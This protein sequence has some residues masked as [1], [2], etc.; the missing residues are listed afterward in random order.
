MSTPPFPLETVHDVEVVSAS[1]D[2]F[3]HR[4][5][6][7][8]LDSVVESHSPPFTVGILGP[9]GSGKSTIKSMYQERV[10]KKDSN[11]VHT[12][13]FNAWRHAAEDIKRALLRETYRG[14]NGS[15]SELDLFLF[16]EQSRAEVQS[17]GYWRQVRD[18]FKRAG[19]YLPLI[20]AVFVIL[21]APALIAILLTDNASL[22]YTLVSLALVAS[23]FASKLLAGGF[24]VSDLE[25]I[26]TTHRRPEVVDEQYQQ[27]LIGQISKFK[28]I[29]KTR[30][31]TKIVIF[32]DDLDRIP[33]EQTV[34][35][36]EAIRVFTDIPDD[37]LEK[38]IGLVF[39]LSCDEERIAQ[40]LEVTKSG[41][42][43]H[44]IEARRFLD[45]VFQFRI[46]IPP[47]ETPDMRQYALRLF[48]E[49][50]QKTTSDLMSRG[51]SLSTLIDILVHVDIQS[52][53]AVIQHVNSFSHL[54]WLAR[55]KEADGLGTNKTGVLRKGTVTEHWKVM[56][57]LCVLRVSYP[58]FYADLERDP[59]LLEGFTNIFSRHLTSF[60]RQS[61]RRRT[62]ELISKYQSKDGS[63]APQHYSLRRFIAFTASIPK[64]VSLGPFLSLAEDRVSR[65][66]PDR[67]PD[68][69]RNLISGDV[70]G[71][72]DAIQASPDGNIQIQ[73]DATSLLASLYAD[74]ADETD[75]RRHSATHA[76]WSLLPRMSQQIEPV[77]STL[78]QEVY[79]HH[80]LRWRVGLDTIKK[81]LDRFS[82]LDRVGI[83][84]SLSSDLASV[85]TAFGGDPTLSDSKLFANSIARIAIESISQLDSQTQQDF[86]GWLSRRN[87]SAGGESTTLPFSMIEG[88]LPEFAKV[89][90]DQWGE[91]F[92]KTMS[93]HANSDGVT[94]DATKSLSVLQRIV[95]TAR[96]SGGQQGIEQCWSTVTTVAT[97]LPEELVAFSVESAL[98]FG[99]EHDRQFV[100]GF[101]LHGLMP[102]LTRSQESE[103]WALQATGL[104]TKALSTLLPKSP[105]LELCH[106]VLDLV[107]ITDKAG[108]DLYLGELLPW[109]QGKDD[110]SD[111]LAQL[112]SEWLSSLAD[113]P[114]SVHIWLGTRIAHEKSHSSLNVVLQRLIS[115]QV[116]DAG[117]MEAVKN[118]SLAAATMLS[119]SG[120]AAFS[121]AKGPAQQLLAH[122]TKHRNSAQYVSAVAPV[123]PYL[124]RFA[125][126]DR[127]FTQN[128]VQFVASIPSGSQATPSVYQAMNGLWPQEG[129]VNYS[130]IMSHG[131]TWVRS[132][133]SSKGAVSIFASGSSA[134]SQSEDLDLTIWLNEGVLLYNSHLGSEDVI[135]ALLSLNTN[136]A[137]EHCASIR[138]EDGLRDKDSPRSRIWGHFLKNGGT[139]YAESVTRWFIGQPLSEEETRLLHDWVK[140][141]QGTLE[142]AADVLA[143]IFDDAEVDSNQMITLWHASLGVMAS[144]PADWVA[145][146]IKTMLMD[147]TAWGV[148]KDSR[149]TLDSI[150]YSHEEKEGLAL[151]LLEALM[152]V[153]IKDVEDICAT[154]VK[155]LGQQ[156]LASDAKFEANDEQLSKMREYF[157][158]Q[159]EKSGVLN[160]LFGN[161]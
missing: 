127:G 134:L 53:R 58:D 115:G 97:C 6:A 86:W 95:S 92:V 142:S 19:A 30:H 28:T 106:S 75:F 3:G 29:R 41:Q 109:L 71:L 77:L 93:A 12:I 161:T 49:R 130:A 65:R 102:R 56:A 99:E 10:A 60:D 149:G 13:T 50:L 137:P 72:L 18:T 119:S 74:L 5:L 27:R 126:G 23:P 78:A 79:L 157:P 141:V 64:P 160:R 25:V 54:W 120:L 155:D 61:L 26:D 35:C 100:E 44:R 46:D 132:K 67:A 2:A 84:S 47:T 112:A 144:L 85:P 148:V 82:P 110:V 121:G 88:W 107:R 96:E 36:L 66:F 48:S 7:E 52:P 59:G 159:G 22:T 111:Q 62:S 55:K 51:V 152:I 68:V 80:E 151:V 15:V 90:S 43:Q 105:T 81:S 122:I 131:L 143:P 83:V 124:H 138:Q 24:K 117:A 11:T 147:E 94:I 57:T 139:E 16:Q 20:F 129:Q 158:P 9:W 103:A 70:H 33:A 73:S 91:G 108:E 150:F 38:G 116:N 153:G 40:A 87:V 135:G 140:T 114:R 118:G 39:V 69:R 136:P 89:I 156:H 76:M 31:F 101:L 42:V 34:A 98:S 123:L 32:V 146:R 125:E 133:R 145:S 63:L 128:V 14:L 1:D 37:Q 8:A 104:Y 154:W 21:A 113:H 17:A 45:R 4:Y